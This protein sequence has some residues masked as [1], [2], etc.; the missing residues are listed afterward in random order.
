MNVCHRASTDSC[1]HHL[2]RTKVNFSFTC[3]RDAGVERL[4][5]YHARTGT[6]ARGKVTISSKRTL[7]LWHFSSTWIKIN[8][9]AGITYLR[10]F[11]SYLTRRILS[12]KIRR[13]GSC[14]QPLRGIAV[15]C[16]SRPFASRYN[17]VLTCDCARSTV[18][19]FFLIAVEHLVLLWPPLLWYHAHWSSSIE[20]V[21]QLMPESLLAV[22]C[23]CR[24]RFWSERLT[25][26]HFESSLE[27]LSPSLATFVCQ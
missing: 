15:G 9:Y 18:D 22:D 14:C 10:V 4:S 7:S 27:K 2:W 11:G 13:L 1:C 25:L 5:T 3:C 20:L 19:D 23:G 8:M 21:W 17:K 26:C 24:P 6:R 12:V 16:W